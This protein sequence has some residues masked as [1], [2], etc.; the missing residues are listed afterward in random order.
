M[1]QPNFINLHSNECS[2]EFHYYPFAVNLHR[3]VGSFNTLNDLSIK[4]WAPNKTEVWNLSV[5]TMITGINEPAT[6]IKH[7]SCECK[8]RFDGTKCNLD[9]WWNNDKWW[10]GCKRRHACEKIMFGILQ[11]VFVKIENI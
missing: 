2:Q 10:C 5:F 11:H 6:L 1:T 8:C 4:V 9:Q 7:I 3:C